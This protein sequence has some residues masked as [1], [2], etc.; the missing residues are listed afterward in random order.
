MWSRCHSR[1]EAEPAYLR[2][3]ERPD[4]CANVA[5]PSSEEREPVFYCSLW[6]GE[7]LLYLW[8]SIHGQTSCCINCR[9]GR[10]AECRPLRAGVS[11]YRV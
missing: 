7:G 5:N 3:Q 1:L 11:L 2:S 10:E 4:D 8:G 9:V 6:H